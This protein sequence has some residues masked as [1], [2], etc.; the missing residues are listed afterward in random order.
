MNNDAAQSPGIRA[1]G[2]ISTSSLVAV[3]QDNVPYGE[4]WPRGVRLIVICGTAIV[5]WA[6]IF[7]ALRWI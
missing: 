4:K 2:M 7:L 5:F 6:A 1:S 3:T